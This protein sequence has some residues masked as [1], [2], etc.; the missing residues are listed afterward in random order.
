[1]CVSECVSVSECECLI[2]YVS[3]CILM[4]RLC[5]YVHFFPITVLRVLAAYWQC[6]GAL[7]ARPYGPIGVV[8]VEQLQ[9]PQRGDS[10]ASICVM[11]IYL[12]AYFIR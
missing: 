9:L 5:R 2:G 10:V 4:R 8:V 12:H 1:M 3:V 7:R 6:T 11:I